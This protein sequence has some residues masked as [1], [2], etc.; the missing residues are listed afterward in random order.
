VTAIAV[1]TAADRVRWESAYRGAFL[2]VYRGLVAMG[3]RPEEAEDALHDAFL[4]GLEQSTSKSISSV[5]GWIFVVASR[6]W[7]R[8]R[9]RERLLLPWTLLAR[10]EA[11]A[12]DEAQ[13]DV[14]VALRALTLRQRQVLVLRFLIGMSQEET[15]ELLGIARGTVAA[16]TNQAIAA[17]RLRME[18]LR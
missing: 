4:K 8:R 10:A 11:P 2:R 9:V 5:D 18:V 6:A 16:T 12:G 3:A 1:E 17:M 15:A 13:T 14:F 7:R